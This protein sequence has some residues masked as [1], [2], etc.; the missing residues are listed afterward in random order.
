MFADDVRTAYLFVCQG[1][2]ELLNTALDRI[3]PR[4]PMSNENT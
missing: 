3:P 1:E 2:L 4:Q